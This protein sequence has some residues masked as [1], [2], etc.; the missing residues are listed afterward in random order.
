MS[1]STKRRELGIPRLR[2]T[3][4]DW[5]SARVKKLLGSAPDRQ[6]AKQLGVTTETVQV[7]RSAAGIPA[8]H[9]DPW[10]P[11]VV[12]RLGMVPDHVIADEIGVSREA[13]S[14]QRRQRGIAR[15]DERRKAGDMRNVRKPS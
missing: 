11:Q 6:I 15:W 13:V 4:V 10:T 5:S 12:K 9:V 14:W 1:V 7:K 3:K 2:V 8:Y